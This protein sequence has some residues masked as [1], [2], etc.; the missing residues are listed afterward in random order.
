VK[1]ST[2]ISFDYRRV[3]S[4]EDLT[5]LAELMFPRNKAQQFAA[6]RILLRLRA[7]RGVVESFHILE[8]NHGITRRTLQRTRAKLARLGLIERITWMNRRHGGRNGWKLSGRMSAGLRALADKI[9][10]WRA[11]TSGERLAKEHSLAELLRPVVLEPGP[12]VRF[13]LRDRDSAPSAQPKRI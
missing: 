8:A 7:A 5:D 9:D 10:R 12:Q 11:D 1:G 4:L 13:L 3:R 2:K 6:A